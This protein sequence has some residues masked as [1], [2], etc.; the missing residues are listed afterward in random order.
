MLAILRR[1]LQEKG[2]L[3]PVYEMDMCHLSLPDKFNLIIIPFN[4]FMEITQPALQQAALATIHAHLTDQGHLIITLHNPVLRLK[5]SDGQIHLRGKYALPDQAGTLFLSALE[6]YE[7]SSSLV[8]GIQF[9]ELYDA[10]GIMHSKR[11]IEIQFFIHTRES[12]EALVFSQG[13]RILALYGDY[14]RT[15]FQSEISPSMIWILGKQ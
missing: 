8:K 14:G 10:D 9:Y 15:G 12:F 6:S 3:A 7:A 4:A 1:K 13:Y 2:I 5:T 11:F